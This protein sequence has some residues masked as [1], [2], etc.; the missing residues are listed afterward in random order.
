MAFAPNRKVEGKIPAGRAP[1]AV[2]QEKG[3]G[4][5]GEAKRSAGGGR[6]LVVGERSKL[7]FSST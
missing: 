1:N 4:D 7:C 2:L 3:R 5:D 6:A